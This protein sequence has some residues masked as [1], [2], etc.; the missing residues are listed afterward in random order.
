MMVPKKKLQKTI[1]LSKKVFIKVYFCLMLSFPPLLRNFAFLPVTQHRVPGL[2]CVHFFRRSRS[3]S[4]RSTATCARSLAACRAASL[5]RC[6]ISA[7]GSFTRP[8]APTSHIPR[9]VV[10]PVISVLCFQ[11]R[12]TFR[13]CLY[14]DPYFLS[15]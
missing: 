15:N 12:S 3:S 5:R 14:P 10:V 13:N 11:T 7:V 9:S 6:G 4:C 8:A 2:F 1:F